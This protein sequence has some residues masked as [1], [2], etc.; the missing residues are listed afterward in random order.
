MQFEKQ[1]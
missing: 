1:F